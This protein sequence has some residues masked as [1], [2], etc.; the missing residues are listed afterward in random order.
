MQIRKQFR[1]EAAHVL[2]YHQGKCA[3]PHGHSYRLEVALS[4]PLQ[5]DGPARGMIADFDTLA[6]LVER[7]VIAHLDHTSLNDVVENPTCERVL[8]WIWDRL[9][10]ALPGLEDVTLWETATSCATLRK[11]SR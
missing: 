5:A 8:L 4:G 6:G 7:E 2:P 11:E 3:R 10:A 1:F 9:S